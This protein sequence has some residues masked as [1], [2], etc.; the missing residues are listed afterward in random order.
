MPDAGPP[1]DERLW[2]RTN[3]CADRDFL[4]GN[5][6]TFHGRISAYCPHKSHGFSVSL[7]EI[8]EMSPESS[9]WIDGY[10]AGNEPDPHEM[11]GQGIYELDEDHPRWRRWFDAVAEFRTT[12]SW[13]HGE[14]N[15]ADPDPGGDGSPSA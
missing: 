12:G 15:V 1:V 7:S 6:H 14:P 9:I 13:P 11:F 8:E 2:I 10:L 3:G 4:A 5:G